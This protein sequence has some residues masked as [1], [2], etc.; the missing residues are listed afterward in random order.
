MG[1]AG[2]TYLMAEAAA[3]TRREPDPAN[4]QEVEATFRQMRRQQQALH[5]KVAELEGEQ[6]EH[7][8][9]LNTLSDLDGDRRCWRLISGVLVERNVKEVLPAVK[10]THEGIS[11]L[12]EEL[13][14]K[15]VELQEEVR[16]FKAKYGI[17]ERGPAA[18]AGGGKEEAGKGAAAGGPGVLS[19]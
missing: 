3:E 12:V 8:L 15:Q 19:A 11:K 6:A 1:L 7:S 10:D 13:K 2:T 14:G 9:V 16:V 5:A 17:T 4:P 18:A